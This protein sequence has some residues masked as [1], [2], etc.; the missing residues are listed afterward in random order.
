MQSTRICVVV[1]T[2]MVMNKIH[3]VWILWVAMSQKH[4]QKRCR[5]FTCEL[6]G[7]NEHI[8]P[9]TLAHH[10]PND[11]NFIRG[12]TSRWYYPFNRSIE[13]CCWCL[14]KLIFP[15]SIACVSLHVLCMI[16]AIG[17]YTFQFVSDVGSRS[18]TVFTQN[19]TPTGIYLWNQP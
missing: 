3:K 5:T 17:M 10:H 6:V 12:V 11:P 8:A 18:G 2:A 9:C 7:L 13:E 4:I 15:L 16:I 14:S 19:T 1:E